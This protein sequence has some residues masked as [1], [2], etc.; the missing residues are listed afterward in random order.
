MPE[1]DVSAFIP[2]KRKELPAPADATSTDAPPKPLALATASQA[3][4]AIEG[5]LYVPAKQELQINLPLPLRKFDVEKVE[6][7]QELFAKLLPTIPLNEYH[8]PKYVY[9]P[10]VLDHRSLQQAVRAERSAALLTNGLPQAATQTAVAPESEIVVTAQELLDSA[11]TPLEYYHGYPTFQDGTAFWE[12]FACET[13][14]SYSAFTLYLEQ[15]GARSLDSIAKQTGWPK[16]AL[17]EWYHLHFWAFRARAWDMFQAAHADR[18][19]IQRI[20]RS[21]DTHFLE[22]ER[23]FNAL[24]DALKTKTAEDFGNME[25]PDLI[26]NLEKVQRIQ[27]TALGIAQTKDGLQPQAVNVEVQMRK[28]AAQN[29]EQQ[30]S[31]EE[32][33]M[34]LLLQDADT[35]N[36]AQELIVKVSGGK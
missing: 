32:D 30:Q 13:T 3:E 23:L 27:R 26:A 14:E 33:D 34:A 12:K 31:S 19:R 16:G 11:I 9:R 20:M 8:L 28:I 4:E 6:S 25:I 5:E 15:V 18:V 7:R 36:A 35:L 1:L 2:P 17:T 24:S 29:G 10:D 21:N 22:G